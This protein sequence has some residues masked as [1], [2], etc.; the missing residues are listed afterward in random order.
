MCGRKRIFQAGVALFAGA[1]LLCGVAQ[2]VGVLILGR[3]LSGV[4]AALLTPASLAILRI[5]WPNPARRGK[6]L[7]IWAAS[8]GLAFAVVTPLGAVMVVCFGWG[9]IFLMSLSFCLLDLNPLCTTSSRAR[10]DQIDV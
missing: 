8:N 3:M 10:M 7:R 9:R 4:G 1:S 5:A 6:A 2:S